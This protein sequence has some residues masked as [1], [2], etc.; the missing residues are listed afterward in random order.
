MMFKSIL[1]AFDGSDHARKAALIA[2]ELARQQQPA[3]Q[4]RVVC[5]VEPIYG[6][7]GEPNFS[8]LASERSLKGQALLDDARKLI[9]L[10]VDIH[11]ELLFGPVAEEII[12]IAE[13]RQCDL[14][15]MGSRGLSALAGLLLGSHTQKVIGHA[16]CPVMVVR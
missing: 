5:A 6:D 11:D 12:K 15:V 16:P 2:G 13:V 9:G 10:G 14:I 3:A 8:R 1:V 7:L 4:V